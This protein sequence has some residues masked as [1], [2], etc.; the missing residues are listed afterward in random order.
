MKTIE[1]LEASFSFID[2]YLPASYQEEKEY[3]GI[4]NLL[5]GALINLFKFTY[6]K[7]KANQIVND[8]EVTFPFWYANRNMKQLPLAK[9][10]FLGCVKRRVWFFARAI[11]RGHSF[12]LR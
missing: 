4:R 2:Q 12:L 6:D 8:F 11:S 5:Y 9:R 10:V 3:I 1:S 7:R